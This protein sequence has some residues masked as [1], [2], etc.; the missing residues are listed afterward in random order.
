MHLIFVHRL[1]G[2]VS[3]QSFARLSSTT[4]RPQLFN[5]KPLNRPAGGFHRG[6]LWPG[7]TL[8]FDSVNTRQALAGS[9]LA[10]IAVPR[11]LQCST[12][13]CQ[14][15]MAL[16]DFEFDPVVAIA[17]HCVSAGDSPFRSKL[18][19][20]L[21]RPS[22]RPSVRR[23]PHSTE[24]AWPTS[25]RCQ[26]FKFVSRDSSRFLSPVINGIS[27]LSAEVYSRRAHCLLLAC[28][29]GPSLDGPLRWHG[30]PICM[31]A[32]RY[33]SCR[34]VCRSNCFQYLSVHI[35]F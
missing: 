16:A 12:M 31:S 20:T 8:T 21:A 28:N 10:V 22:V 25:I 35:T 32:S 2:F 15:S 34:P 3:S 17:Y 29:L 9:I 30:R 33:S 7:P 5:R 18:L 1:R 23:Y 14:C 11:N 13:I 19:A 6:T 4:P 26:A 24:G 27:L